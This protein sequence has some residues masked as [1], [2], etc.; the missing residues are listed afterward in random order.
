MAMNAYKIQGFRGGIADDPYQGIRESFRFG[1]GLNIRGEGN[2]LKC[3]QAL[4]KDTG[5]IIIDNVLFMVPASDGNLYAFGDAGNIYRKS[6][7]VW[8]KV[9]TYAGS[10]G[11]KK[12]MGATEYTNN[13]GSDNYRPY[14]YWA[15]ETKISR[16]KLSD[17][18]GD[19]NGKVE[20]DLFSLNGDPTWHTMSEAL[21]VLLI[22]DSKDIAMVDYEG[23]FA[24][25]G[26]P[27]LDLP[28]SHR[29]KCLLGMDQ[30]VIIGSTKGDKVEEGWL[31]TWDKIQ[32]SWIQRRLVAERGINAMMQGEFIIIQAGVRGSLYFWDT[33]SLV[34]IKKLPGEYGWIN[35]GGI[36]NM[37]GLPV[38]GLS[39]SDKCGVY[40]YGRLNKNDPYS[41]NLEF[42]PS[43]GKLT[44]TSIGAVTM[45]EDQIYVSWKDGATFGID[46]I[47]QDKK[48]EGRYE[49]LIFDAGE[50]FTQKNYRHIKILTKP[51]PKDT[52]IEIFFRV[53]ENGDWIKATMEDGSESFDQEGKTKAIFTI[54]TDSNEDDPGEGEEYEVAVS[55]HPS[56]NNTPEIKS[57]TTYFEA[58]GIL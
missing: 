17:T 10:D 42:V 49:G 54:E 19:W 44:G 1:Y 26:A 55:I 50:S 2:T 23:A 45:F 36:C 33:S 46:T 18:G 3:N 25:G 16:I 15:T 57:I 31:W 39:G 24:G 8:S 37:A 32:P 30:L 22:C 38:M 13:D 51:L 41:L 53:N 5:D 12:I 47:D 56:G 9:Y 28:R 4:K 29:T 34:R 43:H 21:G 58:I 6:G 11:N 7:G 35:P 14:L 48:A 40:S 27:A 20:Q 52:S